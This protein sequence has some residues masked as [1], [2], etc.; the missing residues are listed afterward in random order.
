MRFVA[1][2]LIFTGLTL[3]QAAAAQS[4]SSS[5]NREGSRETNLS[6]V[7][8]NS[9]TIDAKGGTVADVESGAGFRGGIGYHYTDKLLV[10]FDIGMD[11]MDYKANL[12]GDE[13]GVV[14]P[15]KGELQY[16]TLMMNGTYNFF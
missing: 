13:P 9:S 7:F 15:I 14:F 16:L 10:S 4:F 11:Q 6:V 2:A 1:L 8:Q 5:A 12:A 3:S